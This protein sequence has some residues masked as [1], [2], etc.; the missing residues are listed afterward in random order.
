MEGFLDRLRASIARMETRLSG[1]VSGE[2]VTPPR[3]EAEGE[4]DKRVCEVIR[5]RLHLLK[6]AEDR[7]RQFQT[8]L[9]TAETE[10]DIEGTFA[11]ESVLA[12]L[13]GIVSAL[14]Q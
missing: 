1:R 13:D 2:S 8:M 5:P 4:H 6:E 10:A 3:P 7:R 14:N 9:Q 12:E 11:I